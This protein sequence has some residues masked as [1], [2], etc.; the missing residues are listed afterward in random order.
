MNNPS[1][2]LYQ[3][4]MNKNKLVNKMLN[5]MIDKEINKEITKNNKKKSSNLLTEKNEKSSRR[6]NSDDKLITE[7]NIN[8]NININ[9]NF[10]SN[11][12]NT[13]INMKL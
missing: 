11:A 2:L 5:K 1:E 6:F 12:S 7:N 9:S 13:P 10:N 3:K 4:Y 8:S